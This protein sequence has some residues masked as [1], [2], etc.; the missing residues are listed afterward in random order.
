[1]A[2]RK[3]ADSIVP[4]SDLEKTGVSASDRQHVGEDILAASGM[5]TWP[6]LAALIGAARSSRRAR[7]ASRSSGANLSA[8]PWSVAFRRRTIMPAP[9]CRGGTAARAQH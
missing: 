5:V 1:M 8:A 9:A 4:L 6:S 2:I 3:R 7:K